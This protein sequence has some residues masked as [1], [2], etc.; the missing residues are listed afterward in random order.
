[1]R[2]SMQG[3][4]NVVSQVP[5]RKLLSL[6]VACAL[7]AGGAMLV[8]SNADARTTKITIDPARSESPTFGG[9]SFPGIGQYEKIVGTATGELDPV[10]PKNAGIVD[11]SLAVKNANGKVEYTHDFY[12][13]KPI[14]MSKSNHKMFYEP[15]NR[16]GKQFN[17][18]NRSTGGNDPA[19]TT[20]PGQ[21]FLAPRGY[22]IVFSGWMRPPPP[23]ARPAS[24]P[25]SSCR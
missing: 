3:T 17:A 6:A 11:I 18:F 16:G 23:S 22:T 1:M 13:L 21:T 2:K 14:D 24:T 19:T 15:P 12:I 5:Q 10:D 9:F 7:A 8:A 25:G 20:N 4:I